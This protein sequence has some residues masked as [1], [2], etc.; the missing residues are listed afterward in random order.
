MRYAQPVRLTEDC[1]FCHG[2]PV[3]AKILLVT[4]K[5]A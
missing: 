4:K 5:K 3:G 2:D 1:L